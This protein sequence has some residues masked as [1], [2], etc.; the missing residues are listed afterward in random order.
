M[1]INAEHFPYIILIALVL[2]AMLGIALGF[3]PAH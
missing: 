3:T 2:F 1:K